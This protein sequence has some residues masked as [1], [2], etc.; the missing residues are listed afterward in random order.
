V[1]KLKN[2]DGQ[3]ILRELS[4]HSGQCFR[5]KALL[6]KKKVYSSSGV[7]NIQNQNKQIKVSSNQ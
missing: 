2:K 7:F 4:F 1:T 3:K 6:I 5:A